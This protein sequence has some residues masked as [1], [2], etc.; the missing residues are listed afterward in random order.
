MRNFQDTFETLKGSFM[1]A[2]SVCMSVPLMFS[3]I[4]KTC[5]IY[6]YF[7]SFILT[8]FN[9]K[10]WSNTLKQFVGNV[11]DHF[12]KLELKGLIFEANSYQNN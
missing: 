7:N 2:F 6:S 3:Q 4:S 10:K 8:Y 1:S 9:P 5:K 12:M 11:F